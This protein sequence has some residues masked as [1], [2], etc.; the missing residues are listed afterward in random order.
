MDAGTVSGSNVGRPEVE[1]AIEE[2]LDSFRYVH[3]PEHL[4]SV[5][6][7]FC[8]LA[9]DLVRDVPLC[10]E[11]LFALRDLLRAKDCAVRARV[12]VGGTIRTSP[13]KQEVGP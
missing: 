1:V 5:S 12:A 10:W 3:L 7:P 8:T 4:Q 2:T 13:A 6:A 11:T 9:H